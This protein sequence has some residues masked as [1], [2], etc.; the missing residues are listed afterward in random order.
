[1]P[2][3]NCEVDLILNSSEN[4][5][6]TDMTTQVSVPVQGEN[7]ARPAINAPTGALFRIN[8]VKSNV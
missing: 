6:L 1:M 7:P 3:F 5:V 2:L 4:C 8:D